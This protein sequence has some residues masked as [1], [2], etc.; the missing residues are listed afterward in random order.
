MASISFVGDLFVTLHYVAILSAFPVWFPT[1]IPT[2]TINVPTFFLLKDYRSVICFSE[3]YM[4]SFSVI[5]LCRI[6]NEVFM[7][8]KQSIHVNNFL[9]VLIDRELRLDKIKRTSV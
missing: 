9:K 2:I 1:W 8:F 4:Q 7:N 3:L 6:A 5:G